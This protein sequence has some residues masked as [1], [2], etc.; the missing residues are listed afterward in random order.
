[1]NASV[2][3][4]LLTVLVDVGTDSV[5]ATFGLGDA[6]DLDVAPDYFSYGFATVEHDGTP[7]KRFGVKFGP[8][9]TTA[10][11]Y[12]MTNNTQANYD[13]SHVTDRGTSVVVH[14]RDASLDTTTVTPLTGFASVEGKDVAIDV[15]VQVL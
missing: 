1:M 5:T 8:D 3:R 6:Y 13:A 7:V 11:I 9:K 2:P 15:P 12:D 10:H 4:E 14:F